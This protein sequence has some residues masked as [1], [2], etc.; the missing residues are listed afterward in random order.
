MILE[1]GKN[2]YRTSKEMKSLIGKDITFILE[3]DIDKSGRGYYS[4][5][6]GIVQ[7][8]IRRNILIDGDWYFWKEIREFRIE[9]S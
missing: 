9:D 2:F 1:N 4:T 7:D 8:V 6:R 5:R 3:R